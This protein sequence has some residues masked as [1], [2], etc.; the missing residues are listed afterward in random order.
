MGKA[1]AKKK[2][3]PAIEK[4]DFFKDEYKVTDAT[5]SKKVSILSLLF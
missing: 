2:G 1:K 4:T 3:A 5:Q